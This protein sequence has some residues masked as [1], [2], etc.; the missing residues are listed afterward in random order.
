VKAL[1]W[2]SLPNWR[3]NPKGDCRQK[4][5]HILGKSIYSSFRSEFNNNMEVEGTA[6]LTLKCNED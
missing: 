5:I 2:P 1:S 4:K 3:S 6:R